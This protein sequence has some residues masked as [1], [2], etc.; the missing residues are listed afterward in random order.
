M[1]KLRQVWPK[2]GGGLPSLGGRGWG[3]GVSTGK[4][5]TLPYPSHRGRGDSRPAQQS[6]RLNI[7]F[8]QQPRETAPQ[9]AY[10]RGA[11]FP[12]CRLVEHPAP[13]PAGRKA[14]PTA[15]TDEGPV[16]R[17]ERHRCDGNSALIRAATR[18]K[19]YLIA[20]VEKRREGPKQLHRSPLLLRSR[21]DE[22]SGDGRNQGL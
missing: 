10:G 12:A 22:V 9:H 11:G 16:T 17:S 18:P 19:A 14:C 2:Q 21:I 5:N 6:R 4:F 3:G 8:G 20:I 7:F 1:Q 15:T 13:S